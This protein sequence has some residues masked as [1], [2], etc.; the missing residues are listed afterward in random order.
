MNRNFFDKLKSKK[1]GVIRDFDMGSKKARILYIALLVI[2]LLIVLVC[3][4]PP[5]WVFLAGFKDM[6][7]FRKNIT[8]FP[9]KFDFHVFIDT[10]NALK[11][12]RYYIN[13]AISV[14]GS[15]VCAVFFNGLL[16]YVLAILKPKGHKVI[17]AL[18]MWSLLIPA[19]TSVVALFVNINK[20][21]LNG[22]FVP[23][24]LG[25]GANAFYVLLFKQ[26]FG[27][28]QRELF[29][30]AKIDGCNNLRMFFSI[31]LPLSKP[32]IMVVAIFSVTAAW[33]DF[34]MPYLILNGSGKETV[35]VAMFS[36]RTSNATDVEVLRAV[37]F[38]IIPP[39]VLFIIFQKQITTSV[40]TGAIKG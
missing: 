23:L 37:F 9:H 11:F 27:E 19:T 38:S 5:I 26:F 20:I 32:I 17:T 36:F 28:L 16:A 29:E 12:G 6:V 21:G 4:F 15:A 24:W 7:S 33:S 8:L 18:V 40:T 31:V 1:S 10:W 3:L 25:F 30:A 14:A 22:S 2:C 34:L 13:S 35:M 39:T